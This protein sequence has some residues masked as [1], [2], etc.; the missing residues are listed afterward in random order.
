MKGSNKFSFVARGLPLPV[1]YCSQT[2]DMEEFRKVFN[3]H[4]IE[5]NEM[6][7]SYF[8]EYKKNLESVVFVE[9]ELLHERIQK[10]DVSVDL[11]ATMNIPKDAVKLYGS[12]VAWR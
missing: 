7:R 3:T 12:M 11:T 5:Y 9:E 6:L 2:A 10:E 1:F 4:E 8:H